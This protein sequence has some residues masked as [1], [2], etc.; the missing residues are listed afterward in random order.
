M[1]HIA[2]LQAVVTADPAD[3]EPSAAELDAIEHE[4]PL[5]TAEVELLDARI[6]TLDRTPSELDARRLRRARRVLAARRALVN[7]GSGRL[8]V[9]A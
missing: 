2:A 7:R 1:T 3:G 9:G 6:T 8:E 5:I 4:M